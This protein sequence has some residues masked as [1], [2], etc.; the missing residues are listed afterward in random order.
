MR[1][2]ESQKPFSAPNFSIA[3]SAYREHVGINLQLGLDGCD[4][5]FL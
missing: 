4:R 1:R 2:A 5:C 3:S